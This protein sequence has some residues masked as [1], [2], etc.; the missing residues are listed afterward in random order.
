LVFINCSGQD[1]YTPVQKQVPKIIHQVC[2][3]LGA[4]ANILF[5]EDE[6]TDLTTSIDLQ[7][8]GYLYRITSLHQLYIKLQ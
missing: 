6:L 4:G 1:G 5:D 2:L 8:G 3:Q 7:G